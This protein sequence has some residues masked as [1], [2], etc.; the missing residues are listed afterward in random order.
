MGV[1]NL[2]NY[3]ASGLLTHLFRTSSF[4]KPGTL[5]IALATGTLNGGMNGG[6]GGNEVPNA[7]A[8]ARQTLNPLDAN[9]AAITFT[10][11][12]GTTSNTPAINF[13][14]ATAPWGGVNITDIA[15]IDSATYGAGNLLWFGKLTVPKTIGTGDTFSFAAGNLQAMMD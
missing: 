1:G 13:P 12:S 4:T 11:G 3:A 10:N 6:L 14:T 5:A 7:G 8:Y 15:I 2:S 9:W